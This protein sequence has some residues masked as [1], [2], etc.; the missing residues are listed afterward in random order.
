MTQIAYL[1]FSEPCLNPMT[2]V[3]NS[4]ITVDVTDQTPSDTHPRQVLLGSEH[5]YTLSSGVTE[6]T[7]IF[8]IAANDIPRLNDFSFIGKNIE[9]VIL[10]VGMKDSSERALFDSPVSSCFFAEILLP[11]AI[12]LHVAAIKLP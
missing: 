11:F 2:S 3:I 4:Y 6:Q 12:F 10:E 9:T 7:F 5:G 8:H 1:L